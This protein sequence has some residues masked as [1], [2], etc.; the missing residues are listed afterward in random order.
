MTA[1]MSARPHGHSEGPVWVWGP[2]GLWFG[3][4]LS[5][6]GPWIPADQGLTPQPYSSG[7]PGTAPTALRQRPGRRVSSRHSKGQD[8]WQ[9]SVKATHANRVLGIFLIKTA[10]SKATLKRVSQEAWPTQS[11]SVPEATLQTRVH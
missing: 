4:V 5:Q 11:T 6:H 9:L 3:N 2:A 10:A 1:Q 7:Q 8:P